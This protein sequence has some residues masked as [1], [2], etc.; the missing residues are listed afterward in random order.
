M[1]IFTK[2]GFFSIACARNENGGIDPSLL[3]VRTR[4]SEHLENLKR[5]FPALE[6]F[7][8]RG[9]EFADYPFRLIVP[10]SLWTSLLVSLAE[11]QTWSNFKNEA[12]AYEKEH[13]HSG[14]YVD[15][16][17]RVWSVMR[18]YLQRRNVKNAEDR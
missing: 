3:M 8:I 11:E 6:A 1:W 4:M 10:K 9:A 16:L 7:E 5:R 15:A 14:R 12:A 2:Y 17:H 13:E 18:Q